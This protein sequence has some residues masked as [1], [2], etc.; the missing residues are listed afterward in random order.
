MSLRIA[1]VT[2]TFPPYHGGT[3]NVCYHNA[4]ELARRGHQVH[5]FT[6]AM[7]GAPAHE[8]RDGISI[9]RLRPL[10]RVGNAALLPGLPRALRGFDVIHLHCPF[11][12]GAELTALT[13][14]LIRARLVIT[15]HN[16]LI[17]PGSARDLIF[18][19]ATWSSRYF[20]L[21]HA[22][23]ILFVSQGHA[24]TSDQRIVY[25][26]RKEC[27]SILPNGVDT[28][29]F[30]PRTDREDVRSELHLPV[31]GSVIGF[32][33]GL[34][35][36]H[37][38]KGLNILLD[39]LATPYLRGVY[40]LVV[41]DGNLRQQYQQQAYAL[42]L[43]ERVLFHGA[44]AQEALPRLYSLCDVI[45]MPSRAPESFGLV[46]L[47]SLACGVP[48]VASD[49]PGVRCLVQ[50]GDNGL[51]V[52]PGNVRALAAALQ[53]ILDDEPLRRAMGQRGRAKVEAG[54]SWERIG[55]QLEAIYQQVLGA[56]TARTHACARGER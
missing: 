29:L 10:V 5:V 32:V 1:H 2:A 34:D 44:V 41:G 46:A 13:A 20:V 26:K 12:P 51:L 37:H 43:G 38:Y 54:Y 52:E 22:D 3:G 40:L 15:Y 42:G 45:A 28:R 49:G 8:L 47:E 36:A 53:Q 48:V 11:I 30:Y 19:L 18:R 33:G 4:R 55:A 7:P 9:H 35:S 50:S 17:R 39:A 31:N 25:D 6:A 56:D 24:K 23:R 27:C 16:D 14:N 21:Y